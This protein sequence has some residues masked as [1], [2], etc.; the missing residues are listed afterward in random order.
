MRTS[1]VLLVLIF[2]SCAPYSTSYYNEASFEYEKIYTA[3]VGS[4]MIA[5]E[6]GEKTKPF[7]HSKERRINRFRQEL[8][9]TGLA[10]GVVYILYREFAAGTSQGEGLSLRQA[11]SHE[12]RYDLSKSS[13]ITF[14]DIRLNIIKAESDV[15]EFKVLNSR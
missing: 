6:S 9:Y 11:F 10:Q 14:R 13:I 2:A 1:L 4:T 15:I 3:T 12:Y 8:I 5:W 7:G